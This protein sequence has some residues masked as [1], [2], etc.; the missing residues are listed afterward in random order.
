VASSSSS[1]SSSSSMT[2]VIEAVTE[3]HG[4]NVRTHRQLTAMLRESV[5]E[6][7]VADVRLAWTRTG[8]ARQQPHHPHK[9][10]LVGKGEG[11]GCGLVVM[12]CDGV[13]HSS[14]WLA[15]N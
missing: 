15:P 5:L 13:W 6:S 9:P 1:S 4:A 11:T 14:S 7:L 3:S 12:L 10:T 2:T 8:P